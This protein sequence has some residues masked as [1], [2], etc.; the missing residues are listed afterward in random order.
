[1][2]VVTYFV[3]P[4]SPFTAWLWYV[5]LMLAFI[6]VAGAGITGRTF[7]FLIDSRKKM[8]LSRFQIVLWTIVILP[9][10]LAVAMARVFGGIEHPLDIHIP[11]QIWLVMGISTTS[12]IGSP[13]LLSQKTRVQRPAAFVAVPSTGL[14]AVNN[15][16]D[17]ANWSDLFTGEEVGNFAYLDMA[18]VQMFFFTLVLVAIYAVAL[19]NLLYNNKDIQNFPS[20]DSSMTA[21]LAISHSGYLV[22]K[23]VPHTP[24]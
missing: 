15:N 21:L 13:L 24:A 5:G 17:D 4:G 23:A 10:L 6:A 1:M 12:L 3:E 19:G 20:L 11:Q 16:A 8:S 2:G 22:S 7:G 14:V 9:A 18:K